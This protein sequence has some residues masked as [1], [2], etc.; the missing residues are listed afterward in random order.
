[1]V[2]SRRC[3]YFS[4]PTEIIFGNPIAERQLQNPNAENVCSHPI[5][6]FFIKSFLH[7]SNQFSLA[8]LMQES[9]SAIGFPNMIPVGDEKYLHR[10]LVTSF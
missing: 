8:A 6:R 3:K 7:Q 4:S 10:L 5:D 9:L 2:T 1:M